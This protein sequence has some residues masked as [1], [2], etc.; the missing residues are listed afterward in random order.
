MLTRFFALI[1][2]YQIATVLLYD[3]ESVRQQ[4]NTTVNNRSVKDATILS[5]KYL[6]LRRVAGRWLFSLLLRTAS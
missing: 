1:F 4:V 2:L 6:S 5:Y 3:S